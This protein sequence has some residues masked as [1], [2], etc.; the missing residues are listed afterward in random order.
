[1]PKVCEFLVEVHVTYHY[2]DMKVEIERRR[3]ECDDFTLKQIRASTML[4]RMVASRISV[5]FR[6]QYI[7]TGFASKYVVPPRTGK[8]I[9][10]LV[11]Q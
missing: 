6:Q 2:M 3:R 1:M 9:R 10:R 7:H 4:I 8:Q 5:L 11:K